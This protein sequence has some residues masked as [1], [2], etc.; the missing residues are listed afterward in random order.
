MQMNKLST[1]DPTYQGFLITHARPFSDRW[2]TQTHAL[3]KLCF[4][5]YENIGNLA[6]FQMKPVGLFYSYGR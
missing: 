2:V 6:L 1:H 4:I 5:E 3:Y